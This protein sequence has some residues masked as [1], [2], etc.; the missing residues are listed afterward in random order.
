MA[1]IERKFL[2][3]YI[4]TAEAGQAAVYERLGKDLEEYSP[5][6]HANVE[7]KTNILGNQTVTVYGYNKV[8]KVDTYYAEPGTA[9]FTRLQNILDN[10]LVLDNLKTDVIEVKL[11]EAPTGGKYPAVRERGV[12]EVLGYGGDSTGYQ[13]AFT[14]HFTGEVTKGSFSVTEKTF[15][16]S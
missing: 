1:R 5:E 6:L 9:L 10:R 12:I 3:H 2:A 11:W 4:N 16:S 7:K 8:A 14:I 15:T 13:I